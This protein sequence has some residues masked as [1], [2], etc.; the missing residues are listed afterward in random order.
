MDATITNVIIV[1]AGSCLGGM[2]RY[3]VSRATQLVCHTA[4]PWGTFLVNVLG[5]FII[6]IV[7]G[8]VDK[9][10]GLSDGAKLF[11]TVGF[12]GGFT[13]FSTFMHEN[14]LLFGASQHLTLIAYALASA[15]VGFLMVYLAYYLIKAL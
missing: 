15:A 3:V 9:G 11:I 6:G 13:T 5:C 4:F 8:L 1:G 10:C 14:Y 7:Y 2:A 12:C